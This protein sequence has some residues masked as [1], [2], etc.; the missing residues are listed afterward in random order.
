MDRLCSSK[1]KLIV[2]YK[3]LAI[4]RFSLCV[5]ITVYYRETHLP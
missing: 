1:S 3:K 4:Y 5:G 2:M